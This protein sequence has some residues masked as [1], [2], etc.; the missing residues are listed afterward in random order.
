M[1]ERITNANERH[2]GKEPE[3]GSKVLQKLELLDAFNFY[4]GMYDTSKAR[5]FLFGF[6]EKNNPKVATRLKKVPDS[7]ISPTL[8]WIA[9][10]TERDC[11]LP[12]SV[13]TWFN[14]NILDLLKNYAREEPAEKQDS[15]HSRNTW[16]IAELEEV[17]DDFICNGYSTEFNF[18]D[19]VRAKEIG[20]HA[21]H[22]IR[23]YYLPL[24][25]ELTSIK[26]SPELKEAYAHL[27]KKQKTAY[28]ALIH[29]VVQ[30]ADAVIE[31]KRRTRKPRKKKAIK[32]DEAVKN[33]NYLP[34]DNDLHLTSVSPEKIP[35][36]SSLLIY[37]TKTR[38][39]SYYQANPDSKLSIKGST[40]YNWNPAKSIDK[41]IRK[42]AESIPALSKAGKREINKIIG[43]LTTKETKADNGR[44]NKYCLLLGVF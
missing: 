39:I 31:N 5:E 15:G 17:L 41:T 13:K 1:R 3:I 18:M 32:A 14:K 37:N 35:G 26:D 28:V 7:R 20:P 21:M 38:K 12:E 19:W 36:A 29:S 16:Y 33:L 42:P 40:L 23:S 22:Q 24:L 25:T 2:L 10:M 30:G 43:S 8:G 27:S 4:S 34:V 9:R 44:I 11:E 6:F